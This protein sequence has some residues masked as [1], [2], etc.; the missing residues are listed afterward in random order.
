MSSW[1]DRSSRELDEASR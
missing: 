1:M